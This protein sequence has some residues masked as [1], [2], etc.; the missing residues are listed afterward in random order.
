MTGAGRPAIVIAA[1]P[2][3]S[4]DL[5]LGHLAGPYLAGDIY[6][7]YLWAIVLLLIYTNC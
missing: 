3:L 6:A 4:G 2:T 1:T 5:H 7:L